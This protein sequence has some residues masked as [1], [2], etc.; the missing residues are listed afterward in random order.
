MSGLKFE[1][2]RVSGRAKQQQVSQ[3]RVIYVNIIQLMAGK[4]WPQEHVVEIG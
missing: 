3:T 4:K 2:E 1:L